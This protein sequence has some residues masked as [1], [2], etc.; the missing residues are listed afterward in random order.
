M[1]SQ[2]QWIAGPERAAVRRAGSRVYTQWPAPPEPGRVPMGL[3]LALARPEEERYS[4]P[5]ATLAVVDWPL[6]LSPLRA[7]VAALALLTGVTFAL[8]GAMGG[9]AVEP[10]APTAHFDDWRGLGAL[11]L[12]CCVGYTLSAFWESTIASAGL[13][14]GVRCAGLGRGG[15]SVE[16]VVWR[17]GVPAGSA[18]LALAGPPVFAAAALAWGGAV[19]APAVGLAIGAGLYL[20]RITLP[21]RPGP[22]T[23]VLES[24]LRVPDFARVLRWSLTSV[25]LPRDQRSSEPRL[26]V[27]GVAMVGTILWTSVSIVWLQLL[28]W[29]AGPS[30]GPPHIAYGLG[31]FG[32]AI[33]AA[34]S[35]V[36][37]AVRLWRYA[38]VFGG[39]V[40]RTRIKPSG[41]AVRTWA[42]DCALT[43]H[44]PGLATLPWRW[45]RASPGT[46]LVQQGAHDRSFHWIASGEARVLLRDEGGD[47][48]Q[49]ATLCGG[50]GVGEMALLDARPRGADVV[51]SRAALVVSLEF[52]DFDAHVSETDRALFR[53][54]VL[55]GQAFARAPVFRGCPPAEKESWLRGGSPRRYE[56]G[57]SI[58][59]EGESDRWMGLVVQGAVEVQ[60]D[61]KPLATLAAGAVFG[62]SAFLFEG[63]RNAT[64]VALENTLLWSW[65]P[66]WLTEELEH[67]S[68]RPEL[69]A[70]A[71][72]R[73]A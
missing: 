9:H 31:I 24:L 63:P 45:S 72:E 33:V 66:E 3:H 56:P 62:E 59:V 1:A 58:L 25:F 21:L 38:F 29:P 73:A 28:A 39:R 57:E 7:P 42:R 18:W 6:P 11:L 22:H 61:G 23:R 44:I 70:L 10:A 65:A 5:T 41:A 8:L 32:V 4:D 27:M 46:L 71:A 15:P 19:P 69:E 40:E 37:A 26:A 53:D 68:L 35:L 54:V 51:I 55:A 12:G 49:L 2:L 52:G 50:S 20:Q 30:I 34:L 48:H 14:A 43:H 36:D 47:V 64:L 17:L 16:P 67:T 13:A 60:R